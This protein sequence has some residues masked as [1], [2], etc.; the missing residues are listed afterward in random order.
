[1]N[2]SN[3]TSEIL[4][5]ELKAQEDIV[6]ELLDTTVYFDFT[7]TDEYCELSLVTISKAHGQRFLFHRTGQKSSRLSCLHE[8]IKYIKGDYRKSNENYEIYWT[9]RGDGN[10]QKSWFNGK[11]FLDV[12]D[13]FFYMKDPAE[14]IIYNVKLLPIS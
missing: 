3:K 12:M 11:N 2:A 8:M 6:K 4:L 13:K 7:E 10:E 5:A 14:I 1:M 9:K